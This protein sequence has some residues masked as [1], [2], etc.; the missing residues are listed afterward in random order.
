MSESEVN[1]DVLEIHVTETVEGLQGGDN[2]TST[3]QDHVPL[4]VEVEERD[5][6]EVSEVHGV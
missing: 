6:T 2:T 5:E 4:G 3:Q 1:N